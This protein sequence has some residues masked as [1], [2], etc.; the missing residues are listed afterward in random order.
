MVGNLQDAI[1]AVVQKTRADG[2]VL[3]VA[4][5]AVRLGRTDEDAEPVTAFFQ[6]MRA[7]GLGD[8]LLHLSD[9]SSYGRL[10]QELDRG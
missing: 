7:R 5:A 4:D 9:R 10:A 6:D 3:R 8:P 1:S 2:G